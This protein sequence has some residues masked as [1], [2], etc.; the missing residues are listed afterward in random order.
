MS[1]DEC[2]EKYEALSSKIFAKSW[3]FK[4]EMVRLGIKG[5]RYDSNIVE[6]AFKELV[7]EKLG[8]KNAPLLDEEA[9]CKVCVIGLYYLRL[10]Y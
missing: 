3:L 8:D 7:E 10:S 6:A 5:A 9:R 2:I 4:A 1:V